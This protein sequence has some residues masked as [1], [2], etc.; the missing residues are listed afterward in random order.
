MNATNEIIQEMQHLVDTTDFFKCQ[1]RLRSMF[2]TWF[3]MHHELVEKD[4]YIPMLWDLY[5]RGTYCRET[6]FDYFT[7]FMM[8]NLSS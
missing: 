5:E 4:I 6:G 3:I 1:N 2:T 8:S 7:H